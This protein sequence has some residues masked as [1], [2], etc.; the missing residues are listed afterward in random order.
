MHFLMLTRE[1]PVVAAPDEL[2]VAHLHLVRLALA[3]LCF[4]RRP[5]GPV[6]AASHAVPVTGVTT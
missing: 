4:L 3:S 2:G 6:R 1:P 5:G